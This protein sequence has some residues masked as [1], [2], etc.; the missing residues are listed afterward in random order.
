MKTLREGSKIFLRDCTKELKRLFWLHP[1]YMCVRALL[2][3]VTRCWQHTHTHTSTHTSTRARAR[4]SLNCRK[5][6]EREK[7]RGGKANPFQTLHT[8]IYIYIY[9]RINVYD[10]NCLHPNTFRRNGFYCF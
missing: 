7:K 10:C 9:M 1:W 4:A 3:L 2:S 5:E 8:Y 6:R